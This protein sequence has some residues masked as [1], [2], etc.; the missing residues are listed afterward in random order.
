MNEKLLL[1]GIQEVSSIAIEGVTAVQVDYTDKKSLIQ[2]LRGVNTVLSFI[3]EAPGTATPVQRT[4]IDASIEAG[5]KR[6]APSEWATY[7]PYFH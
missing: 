7:V 5:V 1:T 3:V 6:F 4:L 2:H